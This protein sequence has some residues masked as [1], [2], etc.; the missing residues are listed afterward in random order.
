MPSS[1]SW[2]VG[3][4]KNSNID[5]EGK[6]CNRGGKVEAEIEHGHDEHVEGEV[7]QQNDPWAANTSNGSIWDDPATHTPSEGAESIWDLDSGGSMDGGPGYSDDDIYDTVESQSKEHKPPVVKTIE[8]PPMAM[9]LLSGVYGVI[10]GFFGGM[11]IGCGEAVLARVAYKEAFGGRQMLATVF[12]NGRYLGG[13]FGVYIGARC[14]FKVL[15]GKEDSMNI[16]ASGFLGGAMYGMRY[17]NPRQ[18][19]V[20][21]I[22]TGTVFVLSE[23]FGS[24]AVG[25]EKP[26]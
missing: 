9:C 22:L 4:G 8:I 10:I 11:A 13:C 5:G 23:G 20:S 25:I 15:R 1:S 2:P 18:I 24:K 26:T 3:R 21:G 14:T 12:N 17:R 6:N 16:F 7:L 19:L